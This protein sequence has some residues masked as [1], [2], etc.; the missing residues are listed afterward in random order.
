[1]STILKRSLKLS[2]GAIAALKINDTLHNPDSLFIKHYKR[3]WHN[4]TPAAAE[5]KDEKNNDFMLMMGKDDLINRLIQEE[6]SG[7]ISKVP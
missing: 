3:L 1:M 5:E 7:D 2:L 4:R 6:F